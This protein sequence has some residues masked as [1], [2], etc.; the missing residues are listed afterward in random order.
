MQ[1]ECLQDP[2]SCPDDRLRY[3]SQRQSL[4]SEEETIDRFRPL[5]GQC[6]PPCPAERCCRWY[7]TIHRRQSLDHIQRDPGWWQSCKLS[8]FCRECRQRRCCTSAAQ[9]RRAFPRV[10]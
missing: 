9:A 4:G 3:S 8:W 6:N 10:E 7:S 5:P 2:C 1:I